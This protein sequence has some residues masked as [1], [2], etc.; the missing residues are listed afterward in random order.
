MKKIF[1]V[2]LLV[3]STSSFLQAQNKEEKKIEISDDDVSPEF[4]G[5]DEARSMFFSKNLKYPKKA[6]KNSIEGKV[7]VQ[8]IV[9]SL[10]R[11]RDI[12]II[13]SLRKDCDDEVIRV[14]KLMPDWIPGKLMGKNV[15]VRFSLPVTFKLED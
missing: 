9:D 3:L 12:E 13:K 1:L 7:I 5:G 11:I 10:G 8:F 14:V 4:K 2:V 15:P 6:R